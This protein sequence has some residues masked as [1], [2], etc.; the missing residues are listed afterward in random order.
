MRRVHADVSSGYLNLTA[1]SPVIPFGGA[2]YDLPYS[3]N[4]DWNGER[5][6]WAVD[7]CFAETVSAIERIEYPGAL[8]GVSVTHWS[9][10][11]QLL[12]DSI[13]EPNGQRLDTFYMARDGVAIPWP[14]GEAAAMT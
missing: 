3:K 9:M 13:V 2:N 10:M 1:G 12:K 4:A 7:L 11:K 5:R 14:L 6:T 8:D